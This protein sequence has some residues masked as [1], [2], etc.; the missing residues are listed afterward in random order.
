M[1]ANVSLWKGKSKESLDGLVQK[2]EAE[3]VPLL[4]KRPDSSIS[5]ESSLTTTR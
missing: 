1:H 2:A 3:L 5:R 4:R